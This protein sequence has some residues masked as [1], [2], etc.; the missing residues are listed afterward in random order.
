MSNN[1]ITYFFLERIATIKLLETVIPTMQSGAELLE[2]CRMPS[3]PAKSQIP[4]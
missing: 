3:H 1:L 2:R 4:L